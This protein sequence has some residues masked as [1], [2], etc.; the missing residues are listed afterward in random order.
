[1]TSDDMFCAMEIPVRQA[2]IK[3]M[4]KV[5]KTRVSM[6]N[7]VSDARRVLIGS[8]KGPGVHRQG[9]FSNDELDILLK[10]YQV[11]AS[12][13]PN[14]PLKVAKWQDIL[15]KNIEPPGFEEWT[16]EDEAR[17]E[18]LKTKPIA[19]GDTALGW[20]QEL[21][22]RELLVSVA[23]MSKAEVEQLQLEIKVYE[24]P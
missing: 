10:W 6:R 13:V 16:D 22:K 18:N 2:E 3:A 20:H 5:K 17:L 23:S 15:E 14:K 9:T 12:E 11:P 8:A 24:N 21:K 1:M 19:V 7:A 4:E